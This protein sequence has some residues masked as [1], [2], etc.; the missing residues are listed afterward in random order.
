MNT[1]GPWHYE[2]L[3]NNLI[4]IISRGKAA[5]TR[6]EKKNNNNKNKNLCVYKL[7][8]N[9]FYFYYTINLKNYKIGSIYLP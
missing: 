7:L 6:N 9:C 3:R 2:P 8:N 4:L 5:M 1:L